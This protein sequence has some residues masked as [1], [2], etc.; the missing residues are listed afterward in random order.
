M[1]F[2]FIGGDNR[3]IE[4]MKIFRK[5]GH[6]IK[7]FG[8]ENTELEHGISV[9]DSLDEE[10]LKCDVLMLPIPYLNRH[11]TIN[12]KHSSHFIEIEKILNMIASTCIIILGKSD[13]KLKTIAM[14][15]GLIFYDILEEESFAVLNAIPSAE[16]AIQRA[17]EKTAITLHGAQILVLGYGRIG[18]SLSRMLKG[19][20]SN[21]YV[22]S[23]NLDELAW[24][25]ENGYS[26]VSFDSLNSY[27]AMTDVI[28]NTIP[29]MILDSSRLMII[30]RETVIIDLASYPGGVD[31]DV[32]KSLGLLAYH[33]LGLPGIV[34]PKT[35][36]SI[37]CQVTSALM[38][39]A[40]KDK[41]VRR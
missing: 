7:A 29:H 2:T 20:G 34:A 26:P 22:A 33:E 30:S 14:K 38:D 15:K 4:A 9:C 6:E 24:I 36:G 25:H 19:I 37:I 23:R 3:Q 28:F 12:M 41:T 1:I 39:K 13:E 16:G 8:F 32:A 21:V 5:Q 31:F 27:L 17:M 11:G 40:L 18:K 35:S 10:C